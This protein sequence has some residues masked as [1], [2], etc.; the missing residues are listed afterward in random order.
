MAGPNNEAYSSDFE[1]NNIYFDANINNKSIAINKA[2][3]NNLECI[4]QLYK[5]YIKSKY[6]WIVKSKK[7][8]SITKKLQ[9]IHKDL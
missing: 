8:M 5:A 9:E 2:T 3:K 6:I 1:L 4:K 7:M